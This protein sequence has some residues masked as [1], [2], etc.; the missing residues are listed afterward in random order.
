MDAVQS[1]VGSLTTVGGGGGAVLQECPLSL[2]LDPEKTPWSTVFPL[3]GRL[4]RD[5]SV[6]HMAG[7]SCQGFFPGLAVWDGIGR[8]RLGWGGTGVVSV[9]SAGR[10]WLNSCDDV[11]GSAWRASTGE[12]FVRR[13]QL[14]RMTRLTGS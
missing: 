8:G 6:E 4:R 9:C 5:A 10:D 12:P 2:E 3:F 7:V 14:P 11:T 1:R 13:Q